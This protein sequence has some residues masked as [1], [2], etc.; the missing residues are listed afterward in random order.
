MNENGYISRDAILKYLNDKRE[1]LINGVNKED[2]VI[3]LEAR[4]G[5]L[6]TIKAMTN[7]IK[8]L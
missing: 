3:P 7:F 1:K 8:Q 5:A 4:K 2:D 6:L